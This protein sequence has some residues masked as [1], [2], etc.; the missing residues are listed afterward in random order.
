MPAAIFNGSYVKVL[1]DEIKAKSGGLFDKVYVSAKSTAFTAAIGFTYLINTGTAVTVT[2]P[3]VS[4]NAAIIF[5]DS[6]GTAATNNITINR[7]GTATIDGAT[8][9]T[10][11]SN[12]GSM[13]LIS[14][15]T[16]WFIT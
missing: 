11:G 12:Y 16:D 13:K 3:A 2:L 9:Q 15:G 4:S 7:A 8:S 5:K 6:A 10:V 1:K 14:D